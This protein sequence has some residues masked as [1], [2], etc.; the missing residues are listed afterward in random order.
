MSRLG[1][2]G[3]LTVVTSVLVAAIAATLLAVSPAGED[4][5]VAAARAALGDDVGRGTARTIA[6]QKWGEGRLVVTRY[7]DRKGDR[8]LAIAFAIDSGRG[9]RATG[10]SERAALDDVGVGSLL[11]SSSQGGAGQPSWTAAFGEAMDPRIRAV[12]MTW[13][14]TTT[15]AAGL[16][17]PA[18]LVVRR[19]VDT[20]KLA[21][22][23]AEDGSEVA[24]VPVGPSAASPGPSPTPAP[25]SSPS[26]PGAP[27]SPSQGTPAPV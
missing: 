6:Q 3:I 11:V 8:R 4:D 23:L 24:K 25:A 15:T 1:R 10:T 18:Y 19:G 13:S 12:E 2:T 26:P 14:D 27:A 22:Y 5:A 9:W 16:R 20:A 21:R 17:G 7:S